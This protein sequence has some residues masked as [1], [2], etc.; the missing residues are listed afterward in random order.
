MVS[1]APMNV[2]S[3]LVELGQLLCDFGHILG[4]TEFKF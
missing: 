3:C 1:F 4:R 2:S